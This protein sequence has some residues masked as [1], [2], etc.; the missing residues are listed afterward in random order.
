MSSSIFPP[1][2]KVNPIIVPNK[3]VYR[4]TAMA[5]AIRNRNFETITCCLLKPSITFCLNV[6]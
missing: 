4:V 3:N 6:R 5:K 2:E 1:S